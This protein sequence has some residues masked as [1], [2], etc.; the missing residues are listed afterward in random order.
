M[1]ALAVRCKPPDEK[2]V[3]Y[4]SP[5]IHQAEVTIVGVKTHR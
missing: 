4:R 1:Q 5:E 2:L 3:T